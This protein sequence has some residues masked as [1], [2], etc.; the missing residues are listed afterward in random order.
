[1]LSIEITKLIQRL[2]S[3]KAD[4]TTNPYLLRRFCKFNVDLRHTNV[5]FVEPCHRIF[6]KGI[7]P[8]S[9]EAY[10]T[11]WYNLGIGN[12]KPTGKVLSKIAIREIWR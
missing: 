8:E 6:G 10:A 9:H 4:T 1:M 12:L 2:A 3:R 5:G 11:A 7:I